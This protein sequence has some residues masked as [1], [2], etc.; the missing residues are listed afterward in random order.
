[1]LK[2]YIV[3]AVIIFLSSIPR[4]ATA[5][6]GIIPSGVGFTHIPTSKAHE[7][8]PLCNKAGWLNPQSHIPIFRDFKFQDAHF[9]ESAG[10]SFAGW[11]RDGKHAIFA[12]QSW[13]ATGS[14]PASDRCCAIPFAQQDQDNFIV[15]LKTGTIVSS[16]TTKFRELESHNQAYF[17]NEALQPL[18]AGRTNRLTGFVL[19]TH[20]DFEPTTG[21]E[22][23]L[24]EPDGTPVRRMISQDTGG[25]GCSVSPNEQY[26]ACG[27]VGADWNT[28]GFLL[29]T[30]DGR[31]VADVV[32][33]NKVIPI[34]IA[35]WSSDSAGFVF[36]ACVHTADPRSACREGGYLVYYDLKTKTFLSLVPDLSP[37]FL[38]Y[39]TGGC[40]D[41]AAGG[42][43]IPRRSPI[44]GWFYYTAMLGS[45][46]GGKHRV[47]GSVSRENPNVFHPLTFAE[48]T[49]PGH[50]AVSPNNKTVAFIA[51]FSK[52]DT[53]R[54]ALYTVNVQTHIVHKL[55][56][57][58]QGDNIYAP[59]WQD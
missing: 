48:F 17:Y 37:A 50:P 5:Q 52:S 41:S 12:R 4:L 45:T 8:G 28:K 2:S 14:C 54:A 16:P 47:L 49:E 32:W 53:K 51:N 19:V 18:Y 1:L 36:Y 24:I 44:P 38:C 3:V 31:T 33:G 40:P 46:N 34:D 43:D 59:H 42:S 30:M 35:S 55:G 20:R 26:L 9:T 15:D 27:R 21:T 25:H 29:T 6:I 58:T 39:Y 11:L 23:W 56:K 57:L 22:T 13:H 10:T 7:G